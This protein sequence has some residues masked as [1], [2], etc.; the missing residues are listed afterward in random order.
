MDP[1]GPNGG[2]E[3]QIVAFMHA[4][5][6]REVKMRKKVAILHFCSYKVPVIHIM[7]QQRQTNNKPTP[8]ADL[9]A[10]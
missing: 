8:F 6:I 9:P 4:F 7:T 2:Y 1:Y 10:F 3:G 5:P